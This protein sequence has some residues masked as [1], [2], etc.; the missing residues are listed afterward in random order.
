MNNRKSFETLERLI[1]LKGYLETISPLH[2]GAGRALN[3]DSP[4]DLPVIK[5]IYEN[6]FIPGSSL[7][8]AIRSFL[9]S[10]VR[11][12]NLPEKIRTCN[13]TQEDYS[14][15]LPPINTKKLEPDDIIK[16]IC[17]ICYL[18]GHPLFASRISF[19]DLQ[20]KDETWNEALMQ[21]RDGIQIDRE[22]GTAKDKALFDY[23]IIPPGVKFYL[24]ILVDN[25]QDYELGLLFTAFNSINDGFVLLGGNTSR[26]LGRFKISIEEILDL[27]KKDILNGTSNLINTKETIDKFKESCLDE[28]GTILKG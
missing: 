7:K 16:E 14:N 9:E 27:T 6:P 20:V 17:D 24:E 21:I 18:F 26:G 5:D 12:F 23:E 19:L 22:S 25:P 3:A 4:T 2:I 8:G 28:L 11:G 13:F 15:C 1:K 10:I